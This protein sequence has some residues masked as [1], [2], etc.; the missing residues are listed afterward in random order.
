MTLFSS[1]TLT[2]QLKQNTF[3]KILILAAFKF[4]LNKQQQKIKHKLMKAIK[5]KRICQNKNSQDPI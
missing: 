4:N 1:Q 5:S 2:S 3:K